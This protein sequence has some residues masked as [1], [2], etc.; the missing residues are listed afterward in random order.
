MRLF[1]LKAVMNTCHPLAVFNVPYW[2]NYLETLYLPCMTNVKKA[3]FLENDRGYNWL[4]D[5]V[6]GGID[7]AVTTFAVVAGVEGASL[8]TSIVLIMGFAN[9]VGDGFSMAMGKYSSDKAQQELYE[10]IRQTE[11]KEIKENPEHEI[12]E[13]REIIESYGLKGQLLEDATRVVTSDP[14]LWVDLMMRNE[15]NMTKENINPV[16]GSIATFVS[17]MVI[18]FIP[19]IGYTFR[20]LMNL[21]DDE[22]FVAASALTLAA[23]FVVGTIKSRFTVRH[24]FWSGLET[25]LIG[26]F[27]A[28]IAYGVG[29]FIQTLV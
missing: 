10:K 29:Y 18:G 21:N 5:F 15:F 7:G 13:A 14:E 8:A 16:K 28:G 26:G 20:P 25:L 17:F 4:S 12:R 24:W 19:L 9:L 11:F 27:A 22:T 6:Y 23:L 1:S 3:S 2:H